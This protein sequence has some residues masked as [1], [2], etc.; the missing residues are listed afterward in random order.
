MTLEFPRDVDGREQYR[1]EF[2]IQ[3]EAYV[4]WT[5]HEWEVISMLDGVSHS[6]SPDDDYRAQGPRD[7]IEHAMRAIGWRHTGSS[8]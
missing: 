7:A 1:L 4:H 3:H 2:L 8:H 5:G 6:L